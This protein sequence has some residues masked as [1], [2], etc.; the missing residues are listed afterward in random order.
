ML[1]CALRYGVK[2]TMPT[3][4]GKKVT[5]PQY[6]WRPI[7]I[8]ACDFSRGT[9]FSLHIYLTIESNLFFQSLPSFLL[10]FGFRVCFVWGLGLTYYL[11]SA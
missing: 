7:F 4:F 1:S 3:V 11:L 10:D 9:I 2:C 6:S 5:K 8:L